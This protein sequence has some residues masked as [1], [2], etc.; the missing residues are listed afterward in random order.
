MG[1]ILKQLSIETTPVVLE[2]NYLNYE[3]S[4]KKNNRKKKVPTQLSS[5]A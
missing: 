1:V 3:I 5:H 2:G 4:D